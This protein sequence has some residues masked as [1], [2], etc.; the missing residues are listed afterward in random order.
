[1]VY[2]T[3]GHAHR[4][5]HDGSETPQRGVRDAV[6]NICRV[7]S[8]CRQGTPSKILGRL[9]SVSR[10]LKQITMTYD[11]RSYT[12]GIIDLY[13]ELSGTL[14]E[15]LKSAPNPCLPESLMSDA[16]FMREGVLHKHAAHS[17]IRCC[18]C[19]GW[20]D[21]TSVLLLDG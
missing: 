3:F 2:S 7:L 1:V 5:A 19:H 13:C 6:Q 20:R 18:G 17:L 15:K 11:M 8:K 21:L 9:H 10:N 16:N 4:F 14:H 12:Q